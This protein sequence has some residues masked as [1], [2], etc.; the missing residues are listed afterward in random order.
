MEGE[1]YY[2]GPSSVVYSIKIDGWVAGAADPRAVSVRVDVLQGAQLHNTLTLTPDADG[3]FLVNATVNPAGAH[4]DFGPVEIVSRCDECHYRAPIDLPNGAVTVALTAT[5]P[6]GQQARME[7]HIVV[8]R[9]TIVTVPVKVIIEGQPDQRASGVPVSASTRMYLWRARHASAAT[10]ANGVAQ[11]PVEVSIQSPVRYVFRVEPIVIQGVRYAGTQSVE[12]EL[13]PAASSVSPIT[14]VVSARLARIE[15]RVL[16]LPDG[17]LT[18]LAIRRPDG[19]SHQVNVG[20]DG[21]FAFGEI[22]IGRYLVTLD[23]PALAQH[24]WTSSA[25]TIDLTGDM[26]PQVDLKLARLSGAT[27]RGAVR[28]EAG[29]PLPFGWLSLQP[30]GAMARSAPD[31]GEFAMAGVPPDARTLVA[32]APGYYSQAQVVNAAA[33]ASLV[34]APRPETRRV[35]WGQGSIVIPPESEASLTGSTVAL[36]QGWLWGKGSAA[37]PLVIRTEIAQITVAS[38]N[39]ALEQLTYQDEQSPQYAGWLVVLDGEA[40]VAFGRTSERVVVKA[41]QMVALTT[42]PTHPVIPFDAL[43]LD[44]LRSEYS[45]PPLPV[46]EP[47]PGARLRDGLALIGINAAQAVTLVTYSA[48]VLSLLL[49]PLFGFTWWRRRR[50]RGAGK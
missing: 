43:V 18:V 12:L 2:A 37:A 17:P 41:R 34:L 8:D 47:S 4:G 50:Q 15:G 10:D 25:R 22:P 11:V 48:V 20:A 1:T 38:G 42:E 3:T 7:R 44:Q 32:S 45:P 39:F 13:P 46:W 5:L 40:V 23:A 24:G 19:V 35:A 27:Q 14:L 6:D 49:A 21:A 9:S 31:T 29:A 36:A 28:D 33:A 30:E 26:A 16:P